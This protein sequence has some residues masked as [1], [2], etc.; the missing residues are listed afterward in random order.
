MKSKNNY[1]FDWLNFFHEIEYLM[2]SPDLRDKYFM[3]VEK[4]QS[5]N[6]PDFREIF[7]RKAQELSRPERD[8]YYKH[9]KMSKPKIATFECELEGL[10]KSYALNHTDYLY[11]ML[12][13]NEE[14]EKF[15]NWA[16][17]NNKGLFKTKV[18]FYSG[19]YYIKRS[20]ELDYMEKLFLLIL[21][22]E[23]KILTKDN[24]GMAHQSL[25]KV[26]AVI[27]GI[28]GPEAYTSLDKPMK[29]LPSFCDFESY[30]HKNKE[31]QAGKDFSR[32]KK[33]LEIIMDTKISK[34]YP[35]IG[36]SILEKISEYYVTIGKPNVEELEKSL[37]DLILEKFNDKI[38]EKIQEKKDL[39]LLW[40]Y[41]KIKKSGSYNKE[42]LEGYIKRILECL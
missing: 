29:Y 11:T 20:L 35:K 25:Q 41:Q 2:P 30:Y 28:N 38:S 31:S 26:Q 33:I 22:I 42:E 18:W 9:T 13:F 24:I 7:F 6:I 1:Q 12:Q 15:L 10:F 5:S 21:L 19:S 32:L 14:T 27:L 36:K 4:E 23:N 34:D 37:K 8:E 3:L 40:M 17:K 16:L 39:I